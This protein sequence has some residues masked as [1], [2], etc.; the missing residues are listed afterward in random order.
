MQQHLI[1]TTAAAVTALG[2]GGASAG[3]LYTETTGEEATAAVDCAWAGGIRYFDT[4]P[5]YGLG[6]S[7]RRLGAALRHRHTGRRTDSAQGAR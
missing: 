7:E 3:N 6:L 5:H 2:F 4:A 1:G